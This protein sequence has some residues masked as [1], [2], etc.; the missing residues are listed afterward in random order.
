MSESDMQ[1]RVALITGAASGIGRAAAMELSGSGITVGVLD[2]QKEAVGQVAEQIR[3]SGRGQAV[4]LVADVS[5]ACSMH[6]AVERLVNQ[7]GRLDIVV[8]NA[9]INGVWAPIDRIA[10]EEWDRTM[11]INLKGTFLTI[12]ASVRYLRKQGGAIVIVSSGQGT[13]N[14]SVPGSTAYACSKAAQAVMAKKLALELAS[15]KIRVNV[16]CPGSTDTNINQSLQTR[17]LERIALPVKFPK[18][19][20]LLNDGKKVSPEHVAK[21]IAFLCGPD[22]S[23]ITGTEV[24]IDGGMSL[25][26]G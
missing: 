4:E 2:V 14:F 7:T 8:A 23:M 17:D 12:A 10:P 22:A 3:S 13:R 1:K 20:V 15:D 18:G 9:G 5:D 21:L 11:A 26:M 24:W 6:G 16:V 25:I 19:K